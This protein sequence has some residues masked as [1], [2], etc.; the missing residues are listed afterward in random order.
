MGA[1][2]LY[3][4]MTLDGFIAG[5]NVR[6]DNG[7]GDGGGRL[8]EWVLTGDPGSGH[9]VPGVVSTG[10]NGRVVNEF[11]ATG[12]MIAGRGTFEPAN[13]WG[14]DH[15][16]GVPIFIYRRRPPASTS[17]AGRWSATTTTWRRRSV[18]P[19]L[20]PGTARCWYTARPPRRRPWPPAFSTSSS[21]TSFPCCSVSRPA[22][23]PTA[24]RAGCPTTR[25]R[26]NG[27]SRTYRR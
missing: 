17:R 16:D 6:P 14:G 9:G 2:V 22:V 11:M 25:R 10:I 5:P 7:L 24:G 19:E 12:A 23:R 1:T 26:S 27:T 4:S 13:G 8:H 3:M 21:C 20:P 18:A 15:H